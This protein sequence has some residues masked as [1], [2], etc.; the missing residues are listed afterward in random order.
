MVNSNVIARDF[1]ASDIPSL[2]LLTNELGYPT[3]E[4]EMSER[5]ASI[6]KNK[7]YKTVVATIGEQI[8]GYMGLY[9][10]FF[11]EQNGHFVR[12]QALVVKHEYRKMGIG[13][14]L[15]GVAEDWAKEIGAVLVVLNCGN[16][17]ER[18]AAHQFYPSMGFEAKSTG[19]IKNIL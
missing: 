2:S 12:I 10:C 16:K 5:M 4:K 3:S 6:T 19:Y 15:I 11:W 9:Q 7:H 17:T 13:R 14:L 18:D 8:L 1:R